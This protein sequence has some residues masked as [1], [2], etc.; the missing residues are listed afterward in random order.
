MKK[1]IAILLSLS[2]TAALLAG[3]SKRGSDLGAGG[4]ASSTGAGSSARSEG[5]EGNQGNSK[6]MAVICS[7]GGLGDN[8][9]N[10]ASKRGLV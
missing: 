3:C 6:K 10:D 8:G 9:Y 2:M 7:S 1:M 4:A 5:E